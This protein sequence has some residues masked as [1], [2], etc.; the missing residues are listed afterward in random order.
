MGVDTILIIH[1]N[2]SIKDG[3]SNFEYQNPADFL[4]IPLTCL[5]EG[6][7]EREKREERWREG[8]RREGGEKPS[9]N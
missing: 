2:K 9:S 1:F 4:E 7:E 5:T 6:G 3:A 8:E